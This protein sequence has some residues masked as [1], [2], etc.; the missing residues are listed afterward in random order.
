MNINLINSIKASSVHKRVS[1]KVYNWV[2]PGCKLIDIVLYIE[3][4]IKNDPLII[5]KNFYNN[6]I[7]FPVGVSVNNCVAHY[8][9][10]NTDE[11]YILKEE[12]IIKIDFG[13]HYEGSIIDSAFTLYFDDKYEKFINISKDL[14]KFMVSR[15][16]PDVILGEL[17]AEVD[18]YI[19][20]LEIELDNKIMP[21]TVMKDL[22]GHKILPY[23]IH[24]GKAVP[25]TKIEYPLRMEVGEFYA[26]EP[27][28]TT[29]KG[30][31]I[32]KG[33]CSHYS[34]NINHNKVISSKES[35]IYNTIYNNF[36]SLPFC[37][38]WLERSIDKNNFE[39][40]VKKAV[41][42]EYPPIY[43]ID[44]S[45]VSQFEHTVFIRDNGVLSLTSNDNY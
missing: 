28:L 26:I 41:I 5:D 35:K 19:N 1:N 4:N 3:D 23:I 29:G 25:N 14:T 43:D 22:S 30:K 44:N 39:K 12:D 7:A 8:T 10:N 36:Y 17:G 13:V 18:E 6:G 11:S 42:N 20:G 2:K 24:A 37:G 40:L 34:L 21:L 33:E 38:R 15:S 9:P 16:G 45:I 31:S 32:F 27:F